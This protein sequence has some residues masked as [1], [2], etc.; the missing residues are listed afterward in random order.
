VSLDFSRQRELEP[1]PEPATRE[2]E[3]SERQR[4]ARG[5]AGDDI[6]SSRSFRDD[7]VPPQMYDEGAHTRLRKRIRT[8]LRRGQGVQ[9]PL[10]PRYH[11]S[12]V[13]ASSRSDRF[14]LTV[15]H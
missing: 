4:R 7:D 13:P 5:I 14:L 1:E 15:A 11:I 9:L 3:P 6:G 8:R 2:P 10:Q 12:E